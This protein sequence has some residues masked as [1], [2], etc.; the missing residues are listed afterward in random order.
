MSKLPDLTP[1]LTGGQ[2]YRKAFAEGLMPDPMLTVSQWADRYRKLDSKSSPEPGDW[3]TSRT[4]YLR[5]IMD[6]MS[7]HVQVQETVVMKGVQLGFTEAANNMVGYVIHQ[8][9]GPGLFLEPSED[10]ANRNVRQKINPMIN[11]TP[12]L[13]S[14][15]PKQRSATGGNTIEEK[16][17]PSGIWMFKWA[18]STAGLRSASIR[19]LV[20]D[21][22]SEYA[23]EIGEQGDPESLARKRTNAFGRRK[24]V[25]I[26]STPT[27]EGMC[28]IAKLYDDSDQRRYFMPCPHCGELITFE[29]RQLKWPTGLPS[30]AHYVCQECNADIQHWQKTEMLEAGQWLA[31]NPDNETRRGYHLSALYSPDGWYSWAEAARDWEDAQGDTGK[32]KTF[33]NTILGETWKD[34][35]EAPDWKRLYERREDY[36]LGIVPRGGLIITAAADVQRG[37]NGAGWIEVVTRAW[38]RNLENWIIDHQQFHGDTSNLDAVGGPWEKL[39][40]YRQKYF[41]HEHA[42]VAMPVTLL[43]VDSGDQTQTVYQWCSEQP[44]GSVMAVKGVQMGT[45][46]VSSAKPIQIKA[47]GRRVARAAKLWTISLNIAKAELYAQLRFVPDPEKPLCRG[48]THFPELDQEFFEQLTGEQLVYKRLNG[49]QVPLWQQTRA[50][51]E[52][53]D[54][55]VYS[56]A[57][58]YLVGIDSWTEESWAAIEEQLGIVDEENPVET[59][60]KPRKRESTY[61]KGRR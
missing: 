28:R 13:T 31:T 34:K 11:A 14:R 51:V 43:A 1:R 6:N 41:P 12:E 50:R 46:L 22:I 30:Q 2:E 25:Y 18:S 39:T 53:L 37:S 45:L 49:R 42:G 3:R 33:V 61:W 59:V 36:P 55:A 26:P 52:V 44:Q 35:G 9:P 24:K 38:G 8:A 56:R 10:L 4:P 16:E 47:N 20:L 32:L 60:Q 40:E 57:A 19:Y 58:A 23:A 27:V 29:F 15:V 54:C 7:V 21:E 48:Y 5:E 17:F